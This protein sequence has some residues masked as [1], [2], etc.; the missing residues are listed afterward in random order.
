EIFKK[1]ETESIIPSLEQAV[2]T[3]FRALT[4]ELYVKSHSLK[5]IPILN[6]ITAAKESNEIKK[7]LSAYSAQFF[8]GSHKAISE[9]EVEVKL[10]QGNIAQKNYDCYSS[11][12]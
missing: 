10:L 11:I 8:S 2:L 6:D 3:L 9:F 7:I 5:L 4:N 1:I 12:V